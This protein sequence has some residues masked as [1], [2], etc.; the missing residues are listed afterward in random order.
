[1]LIFVIVGGRFE[2]KR[3]IQGLFIYVREPGFPPSYIVVYFVFSELWWTGIVR[4]V[5]IG[6]IV[7]HHGLSFRFIKNGLQYTTH[8]NQKCEH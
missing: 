2:W 7:R 6:D 4:F 1:M 3:I 5:D 8:K